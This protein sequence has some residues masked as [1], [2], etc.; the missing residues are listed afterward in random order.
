MYPALLQL[1]LFSIRAY[2]VFLILGIGTGFLALVVLN[3]VWFRLV[4]VRVGK[5]VNQ[6]SA[7]SLLGIFQIQVAR[8]GQDELGGFKSCLVPARPG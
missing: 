4:R 8:G 2:S 5:R 6:M 1:G 7:Q 3:S